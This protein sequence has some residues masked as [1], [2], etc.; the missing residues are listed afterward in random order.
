MNKLNNHWSVDTTVLKK[1]EEA[2]AIWDLEQRINWG[3]GEGKINK[4]NLLKYWDKID[5][6]VFKRK[7]LFLALS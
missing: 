7:A 6:D 5:I 3:I 4:K 1:D 2:F